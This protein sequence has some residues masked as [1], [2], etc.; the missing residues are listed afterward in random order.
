MAIFQVNLGCLAVSLF[1]ST[2]GQ[3]PRHS[4]TYNTLLDIIASC[5]STKLVQYHNKPQGHT[6]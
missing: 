6:V 1:S 4:R 5:T 3:N 2:S